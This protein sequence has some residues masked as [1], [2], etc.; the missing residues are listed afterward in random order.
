MMAINLD[1][2]SFPTIDAPVQSRETCLRI[3]HAGG[4]AFETLDDWMQVERAQAG[5]VQNDTSTLSLAGV[6][7]QPMVRQ[8]IDR[9]VG[10]VSLDDA[11]F[12]CREAYPQCLQ[13][14]R[15]LCDL[16]LVPR[17]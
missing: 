8:G 5:D 10:G 1:I 13:P 15:I 17:H 9:H 4:V 16:F 3:C 7:Q 2:V 12:H 14:G 11:A 6:E